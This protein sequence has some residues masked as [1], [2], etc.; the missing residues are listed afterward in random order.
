MCFGQALDVKI[1]ECQTFNEVAKII[2][3]KTAS[4]FELAFLT[5]GIIVSLDR[6]KQNSLSQ[7]GK[8]YGLAFQIHD[9]LLDTNHQEN[10]TYHQIY[11]V[12]NAKLKI[13]QLLTKIEILCKEVFGKKN[14]VFLYLKSLLK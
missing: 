4:L 10:K 6:S 9:D 5:I 7:I 1:N 2:E 14:D 11:G 3:Y 13:T 8:L 12:D